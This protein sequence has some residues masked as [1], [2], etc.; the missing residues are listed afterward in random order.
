M[1]LQ[2]TNKTAYSCEQLPLTDKRGA[3]ILQ[4]VVKAGFT[5]DAGPTVVP[6]EEHPPVLMEDVYWADPLSANAVRIESDVS[7]QKP[8]TDLVICGDAVAPD[9]S[10]AR[11]VEVALY[12]AGRSIKHVRVFGD[13]FWDHDVTGWRMTDPAPFSTLPVTY[14]RA[15]GG[16]DEQ[17]GDLRN[18]WGTGYTS[19]AARSFVGQ[20]APNV[21]WPRQLI[22]TPKDRPVP[23]GL[24]AVSRGSQPRLSYAGTYDAKWLDDRYP[25]LPEDFD[26]RFNQTVD[27]S[28][29]VA[30]PRGGEEI[31][32]EGMTPRGP[33]RL[34]VPP[35]SLRIG[36]HYR[37]RSDVKDLSVDS[38]VVEPTDKRLTLTWR[39]VASIHGDPF[40]L[41]ETVIGPADV[42]RPT[43][44]CGC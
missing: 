18:P 30:R 26:D 9:G 15:Y 36:L 43:P 35:C 42:D 41:L 21:E 11:A 27:T 37:D 3:T 10:L 22:A 8:M 34:V 38:I 2:V 17:G 23:A 29:W 31:R 20:R 13:R 16:S 14:A 19:H 7:L 5:W 32:I 40:R 24:S 28:Q 44:D 33:L 12:Y 4:I 6:L 39:T 25:L 1:A